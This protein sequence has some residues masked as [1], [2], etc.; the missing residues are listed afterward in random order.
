MHIRVRLQENLNICSRQSGEHVVVALSLRPSCNTLTTS[1][2][3]RHATTS[4]PVRCGQ[5]INTS[6]R[7]HNLLRGTC[8]TIYLTN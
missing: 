3:E 2:A 7:K 1:T 4:S 5:L 6:A 8:R